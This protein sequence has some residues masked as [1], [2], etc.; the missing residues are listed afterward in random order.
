MSNAFFKSK[1]VQ[2]TFY[3]LSRANFDESTV[4]IRAAIVDEFLTYAN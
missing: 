1:E 3:P 4:I 2:T